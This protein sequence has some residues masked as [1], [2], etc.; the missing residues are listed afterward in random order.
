M[1]VVWNDEA[2][3]DLERIRDYIEEENPAAAIRAFQRLHDRLQHLAAN[4]RMG[5]SGRVAETREFVFS[6]LPYIGIYRIHTNGNL[7]EILNI[8]HT[9]RKYPPENTD[10]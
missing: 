6:D 5:R 9:A 1:R 7:V 2:L 10:S 8:I 4:P 3:D